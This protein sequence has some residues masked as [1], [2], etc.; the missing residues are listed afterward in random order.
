MKNAAITAFGAGLPVSGALAQNRFAKYAGQTVTLS[1][2]AHPQFDA[3]VNLLPHFTKDTGIK[4]EID[5]SAMSRLKD[6]QLLEMAKAQGEY[7]LSC[8]VV[9][10]KTEYVAKSL[11]QP[12]EPFFANAALADPAYD[13]ND[14]IPSQKTDARWWL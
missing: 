2:P 5:K 11:I 6:K 13:L 7:D 4:V 10:W 8:Y 9:M 14:I 3:M 1:V 12:L